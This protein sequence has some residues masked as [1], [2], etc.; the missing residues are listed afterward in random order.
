MLGWPADPPPLAVVVLVFLA[1]EAGEGLPLPLLGVGVNLE[2]ARE[3]LSNVGQ[4]VSDGQ[5]DCLFGPLVMLTPS[6]EGVW[7]DEDS[8]EVVVDFGGTSVCPV[9]G[10]G[11]EVGPGAE[12]ESKGV[13]VEF[14]LGDSHVSEC[15]LALLGEVLDI[16]SEWYLRKVSPY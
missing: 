11:L 8:V 16:P 6:I 9:C 13:V 1:L 3:H 10:F 12:E 7:V 4:L 14:P 2:P 15:V 5:E